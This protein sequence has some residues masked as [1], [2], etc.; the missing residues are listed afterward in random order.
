MT[1]VTKP[2]GNVPVPQNKDEANNFIAVIGEHQR[3]RQEIEIAM[4]EAMAPIKKYHEEKAAVHAE[5]ITRRTEGL[6]RWCDANRQDLTKGK[7]KTVALAAG[8]IFWRLRPPKV[9][10]RGKDAVIEAFERLGLSDFLRVKKDIDKEAL[11]RCPDKVTAIQGISVGSAGEDF[12][13]KPFETSLEEIA[14]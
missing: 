8:E 6:M 14:K 4:N 3:R 7:T 9:T 11:L 1:R 13:V 2:T 12:G 5:E 10:V